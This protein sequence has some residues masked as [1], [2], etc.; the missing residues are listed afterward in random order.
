LTRRP[1]PFHRFL[2]W[3][4]RF[5]GRTVAFRGVDDGTQMWPAA[6]RSFFRARRAAPGP[7]DEATLAEFNRYEVAL[8]SAFRREAVLLAR[9]AA[10]DEWQ[11]LA[12]AQHFGLPTRLLDWSR[13]PLVALYF[14]ASRRH[15]GPARVYAYDLGPVGGDQ[16]MTDA[17]GPR[18]PD[19]LAFPDE[20]G[21]FAPAVISER[22]AEQ[23]GIFT[24]QRN[25]LRDIHDAASSQLHFHEIE[26][27]ERTDI[28]LDLFRLG[29]NA[30]S[31]FRDLPGLAETLRWMHEEYIPR[32][33]G[34]AE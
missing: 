30:S 6:V 19:P 18:H 8:F 3:T 17:G 11:W 25:P 14:A 4:E 28:L 9:Q 32:F 34:K 5:K 26:A 24:I 10:H 1:T 12:L 15:D 2:D 27:G 13:S 22:M 7:S 16:V 29:I 21:A 20:I 33:G 31:L 23:E